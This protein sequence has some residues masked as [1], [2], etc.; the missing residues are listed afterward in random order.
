MQDSLD[1]GPESAAKQLL[2]RVR[3]VMASLSI[4]FFKSSSTSKISPAN[5]EEDNQIGSR[6]IASSKATIQKT[7]PP[8]SLHENTSNSLYTSIKEKHGSNANSNIDIITTAHYDDDVTTHVPLKHAPLEILE[9]FTS[10]NV[11]SRN[12]SVIHN[13]LK[14]IKSKKGRVKTLGDAEDELM[15]VKILKSV[16]SS[17]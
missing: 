16:E 11:P 14:E 3:K 5:Q 8:S 9:E 17:H 10:T 7:Q 15:E 4:P 6:E 12:P 2:R 13:E 1:R